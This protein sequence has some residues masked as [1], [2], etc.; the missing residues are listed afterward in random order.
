M[1]NDSDV[2]L[3]SLLSLYIFLIFPDTSTATLNMQTAAWEVV[4]NGKFYRKTLKEI[5]NKFNKIH[6]SLFF[7]KSLIF[8]PVFHYDIS[9]GTKFQLKLTILIYWSLICPKSVFQNNNQ[10]VS[11]TN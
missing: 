2:V 1:N 10:K 6:L 11:I 3:A 8:I 9:L 4:Y 7:L 5:R